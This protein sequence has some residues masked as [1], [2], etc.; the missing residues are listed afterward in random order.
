MSFLLDKDIQHKQ[1]T[2]IRRNWP[3]VA[4]IK[5]KIIK[6]ILWFIPPERKKKENQRRACTGHTKF[7]L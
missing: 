1:D 7:I 2:A 4:Q 5:H 3:L 6:E